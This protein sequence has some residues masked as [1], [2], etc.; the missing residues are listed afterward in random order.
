M[1]LHDIF[2]TQ[3]FEFFQKEINVDFLSTNDA[4]WHSQKPI[5]RIFSKKLMWIFCP[6]MTLPDIPKNQLFGFWVD[7]LSTNDAPSYSRFVVFLSTIHR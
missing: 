1:T 6:Q 2:K 7:F 4:P 3:F 5:F